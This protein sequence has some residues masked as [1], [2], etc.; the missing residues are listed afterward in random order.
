MAVNVN[1]I[2]D[3]NKSYYWEDGILMR[4]WKPPHSDAGDWQVRYQ[5]VLP[6]GYR[7]QVLKL[8]HEHPLLGQYYFWPG[9]KSAVSNF[10]RWCD[11][12]QR[13][14]KSHQKIPLAPLYPI[15]V[16]SEPFERLIIDC[17][18]PLPKS[19]TGYQ[20]ILTFSTFYSAA[21]N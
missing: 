13:A 17:V 7:L 15:P 11:V 19:K 21:L 18:G 3:L 8:A 5:I 9:L 6:T 20:Y 4:K 2:S 10:C 16:L 1:D 14:G 12:C